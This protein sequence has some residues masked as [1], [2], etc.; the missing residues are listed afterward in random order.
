MSLVGGFCSI[1]CRQVRL[2]PTSMLMRS[3]CEGSMQRATNRCMP[4]QPVW[5]GVRSLLMPSLFFAVLYWREMRLAHRA[6][7]IVLLVVGVCL[8]TAIVARDLDVLLH[9]LRTTGVQ[10][11]HQMMQCQARCYFVWELSW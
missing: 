2:P 4:S 3:A 8:G 10:H 7:C 9:Q 6:G 5:S 1:S 11:T